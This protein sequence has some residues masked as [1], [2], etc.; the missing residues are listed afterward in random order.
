MA[1]HSNIFAWE[2]PWTEKPGRLKTMSTRGEHN[3]VTKPPPHG[4]S[5]PRPGIEPRSPALQGGFLTTRPPEKSPKE[6]TFIHRV[7][8]AQLGIHGEV[9]ISKRRVR[10][11]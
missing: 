8:T 7:A 2:I 11:V 1:A 10:L 5:V 3:L 9:S 4:I 6:E